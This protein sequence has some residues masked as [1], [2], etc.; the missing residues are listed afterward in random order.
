LTSSGAPM[1]ILVVEDD[2]KIASF[3]RRGLEAERHSVDVARTG[4][5]GARR[6]CTNVYDLVLLDLML[7]GLDGHE[8]LRRI[9]AD[10]VRAPVIVI[11][12]RGEV[13]E[14]VRGLDEGAD[15]Y[16]VKPFSFVELLAR[17]RAL[18]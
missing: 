6:G 2:P 10:G 7:P 17:I 5:D 12:A 3:L 15:D 8:V 14:R 9:R 11:T 4:S 13:E 16:L 1:R 18:Q